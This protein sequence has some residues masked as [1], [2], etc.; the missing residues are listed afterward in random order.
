VAQSGSSIIEGILISEVKI[1]EASTAP[2]ATESA[3]TALLEQSFPNTFDGRSFFKQEPHN[4]IIANTPDR[5]IAQVGIDRRIIN[6]GGNHIKIV[7][8]IDLCVAED[9]RNRGIAKALLRAVENCSDDREF[10]VL[11]ADNQAVY[12]GS[13]F[14]SLRPAI[15]KWLA[16]EDVSSHSVM[17][18]D[19]SDCFMY[20]S[21]QN[22]KWPDGKIDLLGY[23]F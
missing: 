15:T 11:M 20:K 13:G 12:T 5:L 23:L 10:V 14:V 19:L 2:L 8:V 6:V 9:Y 22:T 16:I 17:E 21:L 4:R 7:G 18:R 1:G 3:L